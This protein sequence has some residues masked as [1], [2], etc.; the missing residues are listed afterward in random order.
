MP[1]VRWGFTT[2]TQRSPRKKD[3]FRLVSL[4]P[5]W[6]SPQPHPISSFAVS[7]IDPTKYE[8]YHT[9]RTEYGRK[10]ETVAR[11]PFAVSEKV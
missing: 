6:F 8:E 4:V 2:K 9:N 7:T 11:K 10:R 5:W 1:D 3:R